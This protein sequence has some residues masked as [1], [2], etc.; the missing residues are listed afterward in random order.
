MNYGVQYSVGTTT[1]VSQVSTE[2]LAHTIAKS[3]SRNVHPDATPV[4]R[5]SE[6]EPWMEL[7]SS[8]S[9]NLEIKEG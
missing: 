1:L 2:V 3:W 7:K 6:N 8:G 4:F 9:L 5:N